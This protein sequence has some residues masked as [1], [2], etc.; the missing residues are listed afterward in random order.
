MHAVLLFPPFPWKCDNCD[1]H[2]NN[3]YT[4]TYVIIILSKFKDD[5]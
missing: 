2:F 5:I 4:S 3:T 1:E